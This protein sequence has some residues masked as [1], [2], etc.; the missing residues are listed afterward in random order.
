M[1]REATT[2]IRKKSKRAKTMKE[3]SPTTSSW[4]KDD[5]EEDPDASQYQ[6]VQTPAQTRQDHVKELNK[7]EEL[8]KDIPDNQL[9]ADTRK[10]LEEKMNILKQKI[11][12]SNPLGAQ[13]DSCRDAITRAQKRLQAAQQ[14]VVTKQEELQAEQNKVVEAQTELTKLQADL[15]ELE[16]QVASS[17]STPRGGAQ[18][19]G[20][21]DL[22]AAM[23]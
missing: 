17:V 11:T 16:S 20:I 3:E 19:G 14:R 21:S 13:L 6:S 7:C 12:K 9:Y 2:R 1:K 23:E 22:Q 18:I 15:V 5:E 10:N 4:Q 8:L